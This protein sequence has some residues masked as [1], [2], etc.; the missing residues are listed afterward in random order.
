MYNRPMKAK[1]INT[2]EINIIDIM[3]GNF[4][5][6][7]VLSGFYLFLF[8]FFTGYLAYNL[9]TILV[10]TSALITGVALLI[11]SA[12]IGFVWP[13]V[14]AV[15]WYVKLRVKDHSSTQ[16]LTISFFDIYLKVD[17][18]TLVAQYKVDYKDVYKVV[19]TKKQ[20]LIV[21]GYSNFIIVKKAGFAKE[22]DLAKLKSYLA[23]FNLVRK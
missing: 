20:L 9:E 7:R 2:E 8:V 13:V 3:K 18:D 12:W 1:I 14:K 21:F 10:S 17:N 15:I 23:R 11:L 19:E 4:L 6:H 22:N 16:K 5:V